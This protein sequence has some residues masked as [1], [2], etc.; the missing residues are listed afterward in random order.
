MDVVHH[1]RKIEKGQ[2][3]AIAGSCTTFALSKMIS[4]WMSATDDWCLTNHVQISLLE[5]AKTFDHI[6]LKILVKK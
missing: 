4:D 1:T 5:Y 3:G 2:F 6:N